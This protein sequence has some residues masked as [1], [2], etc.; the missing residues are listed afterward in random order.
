[1]KNVLP[2]IVPHLSHQDLDGK[3]TVGSDASEVFSAIVFGEYSENEEKI[4]RKQL[5]DYCRL[6]T[7]GMVEILRNLKDIV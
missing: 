3:I 1:M 2:V 6:D 4:I 5:L 7:L